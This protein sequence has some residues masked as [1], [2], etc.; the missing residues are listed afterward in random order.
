MPG[1][2]SP[3]EMAFAPRRLAA[4]W[5]LKAQTARPRPRTFR[6]HSPAGERGIPGIICQGSGTSVMLKESLSVVWVLFP[7]ASA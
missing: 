4:A 2:A 3:Q 5:R 6:K 7:E 1:T